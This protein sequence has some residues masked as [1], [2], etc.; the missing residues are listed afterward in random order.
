[1]EDNTTP[2][3]P[4]RGPNIKLLIGLLIVM[5]F[6]CGGGCGAFG[7]M[8]GG[9]NQ[10][11]AESEAREYVQSLHPGSTVLGVNAQRIDTDSNGY[12]SV[13][14]SIEDKDGKQKTLLL[15]CATVGWNQGCKV[16]Q[17]IYQGQ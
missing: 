16:R 10:R 14:V 11:K 6:V 7:L 13:D 9:W 2:A 4:K 17:G 15:E 1:V 8:T 5:V 12:V 3:G